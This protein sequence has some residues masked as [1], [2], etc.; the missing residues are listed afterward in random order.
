MNREPKNLPNLKVVVI[1]NITE[2]IGNSLKNLE[3]R[4]GEQGIY[5]IT[6]IG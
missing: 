5:S 4:E 2:S 1:K 3:K 6:E